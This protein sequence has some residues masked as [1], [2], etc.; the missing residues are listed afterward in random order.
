MLRNDSIQG[1]NM[2]K[3]SKKSPPRKAP[4][5]RKPKAKAVKPPKA[6]RAAAPA[7][8]KTVRKKARKPESAFER[9]ENAIMVGAAQA[10]D[11]AASLGL[12]ASSSPPRRKKKSRK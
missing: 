9:I 12:L 1:L 3:K 2:A 5:K 10:D 7:R 6:K 4:V 8:K 11:I